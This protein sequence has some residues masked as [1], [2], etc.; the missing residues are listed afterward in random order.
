M[1]P[2]VLPLSVY[3]GLQKVVEAGTD[4]RDFGQV[5]RTAV[6]LR[7]YQV[8]GWALQNVRAFVNIAQVGAVADP[9]EAAAYGLPDE[10]LPK[11]GL[12]VSETPV[13]L[14]S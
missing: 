14:K 2:V 11:I 12:T 10:K 4:L 1:A 5:C 3:F 7:E 9:G 6:R 13:I 8:E